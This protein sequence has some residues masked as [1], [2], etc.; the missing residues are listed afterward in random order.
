MEERRNKLI[1][2]HR[3]YFLYST[4]N[5]DLKAIIFRVQWDRKIPH[6]SLSMGFLNTFGKNYR[7]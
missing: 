7:N 1:E 3:E 4:C 6:S 5:N 2:K